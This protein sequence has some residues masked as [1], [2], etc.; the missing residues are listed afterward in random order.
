MVAGWASRL[1]PSRWPVF[2]WFSWKS[3]SRARKR[4]SFL[5][6]QKS[7]CGCEARRS[8]FFWM[9]CNRPVLLGLKRVWFTHPFGNLFIPS[10][11]FVFG[12]KALDYILGLLFGHHKGGCQRQRQASQPHLQ[13]IACFPFLAAM[14]WAN[15]EFLGSWKKLGDWHSAF[16][17]YVFF[18]YLESEQ[19][20]F[21]CSH[22]IF[23][24]K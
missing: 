9:G 12:P 2:G 11:M 16:D 15:I 6:K 17:K 18:V 14:F 4:Q 24:F 23:F 20:L 19:A 1:A 8:L 5:A 7:C 21:L 13:G 22:T 3:Q 10:R